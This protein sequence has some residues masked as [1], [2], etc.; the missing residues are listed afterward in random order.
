MQLLLRNALLLSMFN[1]HRAS[2]QFLVLFARV[3]IEDTDFLDEFQEIFDQIKLEYGDAETPLSS[4]DESS[5]QLMK[6]YFRPIMVI[7][8][9]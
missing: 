5:F 6:G 3:L 2:I 7:S 1:S 9:C 4:N 8:S